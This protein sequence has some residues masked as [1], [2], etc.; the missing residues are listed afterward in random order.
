M[1]HRR[2]VQETRRGVIASTAGGRNQPSKLMT[3]LARLNH[4]RTLLASQLAVWTEKQKATQHRLD[5]LDGEIKQISGQVRSLFEPRRTTRQRRTSATPSQP[6][7]AAADGRGGEIS[8][9]Y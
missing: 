2:G 3:R 4:Q 5:L 1:A 9:E 7:G 8:L 6:E